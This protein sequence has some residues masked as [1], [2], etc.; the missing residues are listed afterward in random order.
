[1]KEYKQTTLYTS[2]VACL[3]MVLN[4]FNPRKF[5]LNTEHEFRLWQSTATLPT[6]G[7]SVFAM[8]IVASENNIPCR[9]VVGNARY[10]FPLYRFYRLSKAEIRDADYTTQIF[11][12][13]A[14]KK[15][16]KIE[17]RD[18]R[19]DEVKKLLEKEKKIVLRL[20]YGFLSGTHPRINYYLLDGY[21]NGK[22]KEFVVYDPFNGKRL[23]EEKIIQEA[24]DGVATKCKRDHRMVVFG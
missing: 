2:G 1:M 23:I 10:T 5:E 4:H 19:L 8:A 16:V 3:L 6:R 22:K 15:G 18:F 13:D 20:N 14:E 12:S 17:V 11:R 9:V 24:F 7:A 21:R